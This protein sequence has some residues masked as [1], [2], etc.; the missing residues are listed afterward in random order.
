[1]HHTV[2]HTPFAVP[3]SMKLLCCCCCAG[4][5]NKNVLQIYLAIA[6]ILNISAVQYPLTPTICLLSRF[7]IS[8]SSRTEICE[9]SFSWR[10]YSRLIF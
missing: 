7:A 6:I 1:M 2:Y 3:C 5:N 4:D 10:T 8:S 9:T